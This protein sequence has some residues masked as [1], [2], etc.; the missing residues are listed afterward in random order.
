M[1]VG[2]QH[3][4][5]VGK[6]FFFSLLVEDRS[7]QITLKGNCQGLRDREWFIFVLS[8][9]LLVKIRTPLP[10]T[11]I[12]LLNFL[13]IFVMTWH[14]QY[15]FLLFTE[16]PGH[17]SATSSYVFSLIILYIIKTVCTYTERQKKLITFAERHSLKSKASKLIIFGHSLAIV[18]LTK[19]I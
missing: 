7:L 16:A 17:P 2:L 11:W 14:W 19:H 4:W 15:L 6:H 8:K 3:E 12:S 5:K 10:G 13:Q 18:I 1:R 9:A